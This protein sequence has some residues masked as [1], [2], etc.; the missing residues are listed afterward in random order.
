MF[1]HTPQ[2]GT[3]PCLLGSLP[4]YEAPRNFV[5]HT[6]YYG[7]P[8]VI[9]AQKNQINLRNSVPFNANYRLAPPAGTLPLWDSRDT[10]EISAREL[11]RTPSD[12]IQLPYEL[13]SHEVRPLPLPPISTHQVHKP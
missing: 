13:H 10:Y 2:M 6:A 5:L 1:R 11:Q 9:P 7:T 8:K 4:C 12:F 3:Q